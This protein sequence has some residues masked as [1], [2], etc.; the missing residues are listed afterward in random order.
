[1]EPGRPSRAIGDATARLWSLLGEQVDSY[2][3]PTRARRSSPPRAASALIGSSRPHRTG[4]DV[5]GQ[6][7]DLD[8][9]AGGTP[10]HPGGVG[11]GPH[12]NSTAG[13]AR[14]PPVAA[15]GVGPAGRPCLDLSR[16][17]YWRRNKRCPSWSS[18]LHCLDQIA[19][20]K[21]LWSRDWQS[22]AA[23]DL[24]GAPLPDPS[25]GAAVMPR[26]ADQHRD[27]QH[28]VVQR[29]S[30][31]E[32][33]GPLDKAHAD[34]LLSAAGHGDVS[35]LGAFYDHTAPAVFGLLQCALGE[36]A[37]AA[38][39]TE[40]VYR[41]TLARGT[42][43]RS[44][45]RGRLRTAAAHRTSRADRSTPRTGHR[46]EG[47]TP[48]RPRRPERH[49][50]RAELEQRYRPGRP[51]TAMSVVVPC[52]ADRLC[53]AAARGGDRRRVRPVARYARSYNLRVADV[54]RQAANRQTQPSPGFPHNDPTL[55]G[56]RSRAW[57]ADQR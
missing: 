47:P 35:A 10:V 40:R 15:R 50:P 45:H 18:P 8:P 41:A 23:P 37:R 17:R 48:R 11:G 51:G 6:R 32:P 14:L 21:S 44:R 16:S 33:P 28:A 30:P 56:A 3:I 38:Q 36:P 39:A 43:L 52:P 55:W 54:A 5:P 34:D 19:Q 22:F 31:L 24:G 46:W 2:P 13:C 57:A 12:T 42:A 49:Q 1:M 4:G 26:R 29:L 27:Q 20:A 53:A 25:V 9:A 7:C